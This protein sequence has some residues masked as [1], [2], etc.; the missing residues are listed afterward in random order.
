MGGF[1]QTTASMDFWS[2]GNKSSPSKE[3]GKNTSRLASTHIE[4]TVTKDG[5]SFFFPFLSYTSRY[6]V[7]V[8]IIVLFQFRIRVYCVCQAL[9]LFNR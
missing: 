9:F 1:E 3:R 8:V 2:R 4:S 7:Y 6:S 5:K